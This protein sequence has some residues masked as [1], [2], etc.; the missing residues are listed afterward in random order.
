MS[1]YCFYMAAFYTHFHVLQH[2]RPLRDTFIVR[3][4]QGSPGHMHVDDEGLP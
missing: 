2:D 4:V 3:T 1:V